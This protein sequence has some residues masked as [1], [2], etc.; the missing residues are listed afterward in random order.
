MQRLVGF[1]H[2]KGRL[3]IKAVNATICQGGGGPAAADAVIEGAKALDY[4]T[5][6]RPFLGSTTDNAHDALTTFAKRMLEFY[7][8]R[9]RANTPTF[10]NIHVHARAHTHAHT[11]AHTQIFP[12]PLLCFAYRF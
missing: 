5:L 4:G 2:L 11:H 10:P 12:S 3:W 9:R 7:E 8:G 6:L 1:D